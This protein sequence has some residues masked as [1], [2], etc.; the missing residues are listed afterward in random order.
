MGRSGWIAAALLLTTMAA[1]AQAP[2]SPPQ[3]LDEVLDTPTRAGIV[4]EYARQLAATHVNAGKAKL[5]AD[6][7]RKRLA[8]GDYDDVTSARVLSSRVSRDLA[9]VLPDRHTRLE[10]VPYDLTDIRQRPAPPLPPADNFGLRKYEA[11]AGN[12]GYVQINRFAP[13]DRA[14]VEAVGRFMSQA[15]DN[16]A[17]I[18]DL[19]DAA[20][21]SQEMAAWLSSY[22]LTDTRSY[23][24]ID[25]QIHLHDQV[26]RDGKVVTEYWTRADVAGKRFG[27]RKPLYVLVSERTG[28]AAEGFAYD[29]QQY[30][31]AVVVGAPTQGD[32]Q[33]RAA[34][35]V[36]RHLLASISVTRAVNNISRSNWESIGIQPDRVVAPRDAL[37]EALKLATAT[38]KARMDA[39]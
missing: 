29:L 12:I 17:L 38:I 20:G 39:K 2:T 14:S 7:L 28:A 36:S 15:A 22:V 35:P 1:R 8:R 25:K 9:E 24:I 10:Y 19:R 23:V 34:P 3:A 6:D 11:L 21:D 5:A 27:G 4:N 30:K 26:D 18:I 13:V 16:A 32:A 31:R 37:D 33:V